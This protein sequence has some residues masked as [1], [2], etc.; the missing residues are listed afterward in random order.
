M[1]PSLLRSCW[2]A[3]IIISRLSSYAFAQ[4][5]A[6]EE[7]QTMLRQLMAKPDPRG[8]V[9]TLHNW[10]RNWQQCGYP[11]DSTYI[12]GLLQLGLAYH[13]RYD[14]ATATQIVQQAVQLCRIRRPDMSP[15][16]PSKA[17]YRLSMLLTDQRQPAMETIKQAIR[18]GQGIRSADRWV[19]EAY[20]YLAYAYY[21][22]GDFQQAIN[23]AESGELL[24]NR[25]NDKALITQLLQEKIIA[26]NELGRYEAAHQTAK[27]ALV[28]A[29]QEGYPLVIARA[30]QVLGGIAEKQNQLTDALQYTLR[31]FAIAKANGDVSAPNYSVS[32]G[33]LYAQLHQFDKAISYIQYGVDRNTNDYDKAYALAMLGQVYGQK[34]D[35]KKALQYYQK[36]LVTMPIGFRNAIVTSLPDPRSIQLADQKEYLLTLIR[37]KANAWLCSAK[38]T[39]RDLQQLQQALATYKVAD[40]MID[41]MRWEH[42]G[43]QSKLYWRQ[44]TRN[45]YEQA[46][47]TCFQLEN[48]EQAFRFMEKS[49]AVMLTDRLN[50][51]GARQKLDERQIKQEEQLQNEV[52]NQQT[53]LA[54]IN[55][56]DSVAYHSARMNLLAKQ[57]S[58]TAFRKRLEVSNP[59]YYDYK[60]NT[61]IT[62][63]DSLRSH[64][65][66][67]N[68]SFVTYFI[69][70][71][72]L[73]VLGVT[74][75]TSCMLRQSLHDYRQNVQAYMKL[76]WSSD[77]MNRKV[78]YTQFLALGNG[79]YNQL[80]A[81]LKLPAGRV[82]V[83]PDGA[84][85]PFETLSRKTNE[86]DYLVNDYAFSYVYSV[87]SL[88]KK[89]EKN[90]V[91]TAK[92]HYDFLGIAPVTF[93]L[94][95]NQ[96]TLPG[97]EESLNRIAERFH[98]PELLTNQ[99]ATRRS[100]LTKA[101]E[102]SVIHL[103]THATA[104]SS[105]Q[106]PTLYFADS[107]LKL[108]DLDDGALPNVE[109]AVLAACKT[110]IGAV[111]QGEGVFS[112]ARGFAALG[113]PSVLTT[114]WSVQ[115]NATYKLTESFYKYLN[116]GLPK[117]IAL[118]YAKRDWL[119]EASRTDQLPNFWA[120]LIIVGDT[121][122]LSRANKGL[123]TALIPLMT[124]GVWAWQKQ[125]QKPKLPVS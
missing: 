32:V 60:Y 44:T 61:T 104:D 63:L 3:W 2:I 103:F 26:L 123:W 54:N 79:L 124:F 87:R 108:S 50:E 39:G 67:Q 4:C 106:D 80:L 29:R 41:F 121:T 37:S 74:A 23:S 71:S 109:L 16:Q 55:P 113:V 38:V 1:K 97:S 18:Q 75:D 9:N 72:S 53:K 12:N 5:P 77:A 13:A 91:L 88:L 122:P 86:P 90:E 110:G 69:G 64:L 30:Y 8:Q 94:S 42:T 68:A 58:L 48:A 47:E 35:Y 111:Q 76:L 45:V 115:D 117:D 105:G 59:A 119:E 102:A 7:L 114:L 21:S 24:A 6:R 116:E 81:P 66:R 125:K 70:D 36:G 78:N 120:G 85:I 100:F 40:Q 10:Q 15:E 27:R 25:V 84:S 34:K 31:A 118:Q 93:A 99:A 107:T 82:I 98:S 46:L 19:G 28:L 96:V 49:R 22:A 56:K 89:R 92:R 14:Y 43:Q 112:F 51:L 20:L 33:I 57:D 73:Y 95:L 11:T 52:S 101:A 62:S 17:L 65:K 83:S